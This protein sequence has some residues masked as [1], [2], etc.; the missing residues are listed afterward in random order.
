MIV[1]LLA[2]LGVPAA[3]QAKPTFGMR[4]YAI[5]VSDAT[6]TLDFHGDEEAG[7]AERGVCSTSGTA[8]STTHGQSGG[9]GD[10]VVTGRQFAGSMSAFVDGETTSTV[11]TP[12]APGCTD[13]VTRTADAFMMLADRTGPLTFG[14]GTQLDT[15]TGDGGEAGG[16]D[17]GSSGGDD[18]FASHCAGPLLDDIAPALPR[19]ELARSALRQKT[20]LVTFSGS[21]PFSGGGF[22]GTVTSDMQITLRRQV[23]RGKR[24]RSYCRSFDRMAR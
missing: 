23:C 18:P 24:T 11:E 14:Y 5:E 2:A 6:L 16:A 12:G 21:R 17:L 22:A 9:F 7:C 3:G 15:Q 4:T 13:T 8:T 19:A 1:A 10:I 20:M